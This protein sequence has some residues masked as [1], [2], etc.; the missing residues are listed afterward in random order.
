[1]SKQSKN[2]WII[3]FGDFLRPYLENDTFR[4]RS[5]RSKKNI[6]V[7]LRRFTSMCSRYLLCIHARIFLKGAVVIWSYYSII[8]GPR[9]EIIINVICFEFSVSGPLCVRGIE[10]SRGCDEIWEVT[11]ETYASSAHMPFYTPCDHKM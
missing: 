11:A 6:D 4:D 10:Y 5:C 9:K 2:Y 7:D 1:M 8:H 3:D